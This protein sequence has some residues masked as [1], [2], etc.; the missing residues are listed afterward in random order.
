MS[1]LLKTIS[2]NKKMPL[3]IKIFEVS[4]V[5]IKD[6]DTGESWTDLCSLIHDH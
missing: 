1:G 2:A 4:D 6:P 5:V 3:P